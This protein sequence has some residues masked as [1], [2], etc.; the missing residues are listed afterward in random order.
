MMERLPLQPVEVLVGQ[1]SLV[2]RAQDGWRRLGALLARRPP[3]PERTALRPS[4]QLDVSQL[5]VVPP[6]ERALRPCAGSASRC[7]PAMHWGDRRVGGRQVHAGPRADRRLAPPPA[8]SGWAD[9]LDQFPFGRTG[10]L[11]RLSAPAGDAV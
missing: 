8:A 3:V 6:G 11:G 10:P 1:W 9:T 7:R 5:S 4:A 2:Q